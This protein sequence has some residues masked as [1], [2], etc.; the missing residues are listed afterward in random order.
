M[1]KSFHLEDEFQ[2]KLKNPIF[3]E[4]FYEVSS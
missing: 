4:I 3:Y 2:K 1:L